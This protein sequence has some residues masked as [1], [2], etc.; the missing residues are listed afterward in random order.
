MSK[1]IKLMLNHTSNGFVYPAGDTIE[2]S[3][4][5]YEFLQSA[6]AAKRAEQAEK[7]RELNALEQLIKDNT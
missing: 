7:I 3:D 6:Y 1:F 5:D 4:E 2:V